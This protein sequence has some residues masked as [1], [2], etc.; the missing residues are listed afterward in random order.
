MINQDVMDLYNRVPDGNHVIVLTDD[1]QFPTGLHVPPKAPAKKP[2]P[3]ATTVAATPD[4]VEE[5]LQTEAPLPGMIIGSHP[6]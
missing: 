4:P 1:G 2:K 3:V 5:P 6:I